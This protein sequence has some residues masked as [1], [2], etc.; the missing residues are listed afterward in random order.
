MKR[1]MYTEDHE[2]FRNSVRQFLQAEVVPFHKEWEHAG[3]VPRSIWEK[4]GGQGFLCTATAEKYGGAG[5]DFLYSAIV[6]EE[7]GRVFNH[8]FAM[9]L[10]SD[11]IVPYLESFGSEEQK[12]RW[13][14]GCVAGKLITA[15]AMTEPGAG[16]DLQGVRTTAIR[17][18][19]HY[20]V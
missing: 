17:D 20:V 19:D 12:E 3:I 11:I 8:G 4:A 14:P 1:R 2:I 10:H 9:G 5:A 7:C 6:S 13:L 15:I 18:G 16:S